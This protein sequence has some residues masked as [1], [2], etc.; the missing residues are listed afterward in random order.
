[1]HL[2]RKFDT[3][4]ILDNGMLKNNSE[5]LR[6]TTGIGLSNWNDNLTEIGNSSC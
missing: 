5:L 6:K 2:L 3:I 1:M 4:V